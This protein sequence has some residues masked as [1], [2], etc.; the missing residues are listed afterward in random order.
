MST[1]V[2]FRPMM[3]KNIHVKKFLSLDY[4]MK[5]LALLRQ[6]SAISNDYSNF[7]NVYSNFRPF[8]SPL[9]N[10]TGHVFGQNGVS[11]VTSAKSWKTR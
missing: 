2:F 11:V 9:L 6:D 8:I 1:L 4:E 3:V 10:V 7:S 5:R